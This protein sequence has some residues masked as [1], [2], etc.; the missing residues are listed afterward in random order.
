VGDG[1][2]A[3]LG[4][5]CG[6]VVAPANLGGVARSVAELLPRPFTELTLDDVAQII[7]TTG[8]ERETL[9]FERKASVTTNSLA[10]A[11]AAFANTYGSL[12]VVGVGDQNDAL[13]GSS[14]SQP[15]RRS[16]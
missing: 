10:K 2:S 13:A 12:L 3:G 6:P 15:R 5:S 16:G 7:A 11:R 4:G 14:P 1:V 9:W 8:E